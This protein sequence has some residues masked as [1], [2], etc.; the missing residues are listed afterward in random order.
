VAWQRVLDEV[1]RKKPMLGGTLAQVVP[2]GIA[3]G[4]LT[5]RLSGTGFHRD[6]LGDAANRE[7]LTQA[8]RRFVAGAE[9]VEVTMQGETD[10]SPSGHPAVKA[11]KEIFQGEVV[12]VRPRLPEGEGQ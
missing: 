6:M 11:A 7:V 9:R 2:G 3:N 1:N 10:S 8:V 5:L 12:A 4:T